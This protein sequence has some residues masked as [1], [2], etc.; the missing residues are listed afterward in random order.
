[1]K[2]FILLCVFAMTACITAFAQ[3]TAYEKKVE[4]IC[5]KYYS[6]GKYGNEV[7]LNAEDLLTISKFGGEKAARLS[8]I[9]YSVTHDSEQARSWMNSFE[10]ELEKAKSLMTNADFHK[11]FLKSSYG[12]ATMQ[13][14]KA[15]DESVVKDEFETQAQFEERVK[16]EAADV[17]DSICSEMVDLMNSTLMITISPKSYDAD[18]E[19]YNIEI[20]EVFKIAENNEIKNNYEIS[21]P[22]ETD[23][24]RQYNG[25]TISPEA[26]ESVVWVN[27]G[28][29]LHAQEVSY[30]NDKGDIQTFVSNLP[31]AQL[32]VFSYDKF[33]EPHPLLPDYVWK[34]SSLNNYYG[35]YSR[36]LKMAID[37]FNNKIATD[38]YYDSISSHKFLLNANDYSLSK[39][40]KTDKEA[41]RSALDSQKSK[42]A[43]DYANA[44]KKIAKDCRE[45]APNRF[46]AVYASEHPD[47]EAK[48]SALEYDYR[49]YNFSYNELAFFVIDDKM[50]SQIKCYDKYSDLF[51]NRDEFNSFYITAA[52]FNKEVSYREDIRKRF[53][54]IL[55]K[56]PMEK[57]MSFK[58]AKNGK[59]IEMLEYMD[60]I[61][62]FKIVDS[63]Y[64]ATLEAYLKA[65]AKMNKE[66]SKVSKFF[67]GK[68]EFFE[69]Y[70]SP[71]YSKILKSN[72]A[73]RK[74]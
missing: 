16:D 55:S 50:P 9:N 45:N 60:A 66:Y 35:T 33:A 40:D 41:L 21:L 43:T 5:G 23:L 17:F 3:Q 70:T 46:V 18:N 48:V 44:L 28:D 2:K 19:T 59:N 7:E 11:I 65:D 29:E 62:E 1:M 8:L 74:N 67:N 42:M 30:I 37:G 26:I 64:Y 6:L 73:S 53:M 57:S 47:F 49:C 31:D 32:L 14:K 61:E 10:K 69:A 39:V 4:E 24:A 25:E 72:K 15:F 38:K 20:E 68:K 71:N 36:K 22:M 13:V 54:A 58:G 12:R 52:R 27:D 34:S 63:W 51:N 56:A